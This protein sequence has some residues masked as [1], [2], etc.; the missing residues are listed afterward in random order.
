MPVIIEEN[1]IFCLQENG[2]WHCYN[3][4]VND[5]IEMERQGNE[6]GIFDR[7]SFGSH[8]AVVDG[9]SITVSFDRGGKMQPCKK[10][11]TTGF[12]TLRC[13]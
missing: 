6:I 7:V 9:N 3:A 1:G 4:I 5:S 10:Y 12:E 2:R 13:D 11:G 8:Q